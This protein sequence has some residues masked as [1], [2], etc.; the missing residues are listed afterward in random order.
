MPID[1][2]PYPRTASSEPACRAVVAARELRRRAEAWRQRTAAAPAFAAAAAFAAL[3]EPG[4]HLLP[5]ILGLSLGALGTGFGVASVASARFTYSVPLPGDS[6]FKTPPGA[7]VRMA[8]VQLATMGVM[9]VLLIPEI[10]L[11]AAQLVTGNAA[12]G[13]TALAVGLLAMLRAKVETA[14]TT[15]SDSRVIIRS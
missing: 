1:P 15:T 3:H 9:G 14:T 4:V 11:V 8:V 2:R 6:P 7:G 12:F 13:W 10:G 5:A